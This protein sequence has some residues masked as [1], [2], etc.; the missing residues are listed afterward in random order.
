[1]SDTKVVS[2]C[3]AIDNGR[4]LLTRRAPGQKLEGMW[5][6]PGGK[7]ED[8]LVVRRFRRE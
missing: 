1:M 2:A 4:V 3:V 7:L 6:F 8:E 5:E